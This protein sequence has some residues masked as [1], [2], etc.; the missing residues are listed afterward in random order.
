MNDRWP[1]RSRPLPRWVEVACLLAI[2]AVAVGLRLYQIGEIPPGPHYDEASATFDALDV[3]AGRHTVFSLRP[4]GRE[5]L[6]V[7]VAAPLVSL[8]G[9]GRLAI[10]LPTAIV[11]ILTIPATYLL[12][13]E[14]FSKRDL[15]GKGSFSGDTT[16]D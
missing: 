15:W 16:T 5:M 10:R 12:V 3:L 9:P 4:F 8:L 11:G 2:T 6:F 14:M 1:Y 7:Y 13:R